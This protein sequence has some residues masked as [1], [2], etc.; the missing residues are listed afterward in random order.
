MTS[1]YNQLLQQ[2]LAIYLK[3]CTV[4]ADVLKM[5]TCVFGKE[6]LIFDKIMAFSN[7][8]KKLGYG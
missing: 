5:Y 3:L 4:V 2:F 8:E 6:K 1:L 7:L